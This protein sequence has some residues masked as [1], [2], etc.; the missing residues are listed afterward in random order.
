MAVLHFPQRTDEYPASLGRVDFGPAG[1]TRSFSCAGAVLRR[2]TYLQL[3]GFAPFFFH[4]YE[5]PD[6]A[7][8]CVVAGYDIYFSPSLTIRHHYSGTARNER[9]TH[10]R[11]ARNE[12]WSALI[13][14]PFPYVIPVTIYRIFSQF[15][16]ACSRGW[17]WIVREPAWW[18]QALAGIP[19]CLRA[20]QPVPWAAYRTW[21]GLPENGFMPELRRHEA[22]PPSSVQEART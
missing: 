9:R 14:V 16:Y 10:H 6:Y 21:L 22:K 1:A 20:R 19:R 13:H 5:E 15:R 18:L 2:S 3:R 12:F 8:Q 11:H 17:S 4:A 7:L